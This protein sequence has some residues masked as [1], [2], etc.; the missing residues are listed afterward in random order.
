MI[1]DQWKFI[2]KLSLYGKSNFH[3]C[4]SN[5]FTVISLACT[6]RTRNLPNFLRRRTTV[7]G[8]ARRINDIS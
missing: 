7:D 4:R 5:Q 1:I 8:T 6:L 3:F 2:T